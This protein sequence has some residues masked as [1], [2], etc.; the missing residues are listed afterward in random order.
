MTSAVDGS[1]EEVR[2]RRG[3]ACEVLSIG[4]REGTPLVFLHGAAGLLDDNRFL[5]ALGDSGYRVLAPELPGYGRSTGEEL[6]ED[7]LDF[8]LHGWDV[9]DALGVDRP[10]LVAHSMGGMIAAEMAAVC[11]ARPAA[12]VLVAPNGLWDDEH[13]VADLFSLLPFQFAEVLFADPAA[14]AA[15]LTGGVDFDD[16]DALAEFYIANA[17]RLGTAGKIL[18]PIPNRRLAKRLY[19]VTA[20]AMLAWGTEDA[21]IP[22]SYASRWASLL[23]GSPVVMV[24][25]SGHM[26]PYE[27]P[28]RLAA[29]VVGF[30]DSR[31]L[32][33]RPA[34]PGGS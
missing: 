16:M 13:P 19:R 11:P 34:V 23:P 32:S 28:D 20:P 4:P 9:V 15:L 21:Y 31:L 14:G 22:P 30:L 26:V 5:A 1:V 25:G 12:L 8:T 18:F 33:P 27:Q 6:L 10:V 29:A 17:R 24:E 3:A 2:T 7:M